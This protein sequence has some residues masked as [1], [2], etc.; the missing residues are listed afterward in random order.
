MFKQTTDHQI[1]QQQIGY[2]FSN[3]NLIRQAFVRK[4]FSSEHGGEDNEVLEF[5]GDKVLDFVVVKYLAEKYGNDL[6]AHDEIPLSF[7][8]SEDFL[9]YQCDYS[10]GELTKIKQ[11]LVERKTLAKRIDELGLAQFLIMGEG[12]KKRRVENE[13]SVKED[14]FEAIIG[15]VALDCNWNLNILQ[16]VVLLMLC[17]E[18]FL[19]DDEETDYVGLIYEWDEKKNGVIPQFWYTSNSVSG[20]QTTQ[21]ANPGFLDFKNNAE[22]RYFCKVQLLS[23]LSPF[24]GCGSSKHD[25]RKDACKKAYEYLE[26]NDML[27]DIHDEIANPCWEDSISQLETLSRRGYFEIPKYIYKESH[28]KN[29]NPIWHVECHIEDYDDFFWAEGSSKKNAKKDAAYSMLCFV[30]DLEE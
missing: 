12:D 16:E 30:L 13:D 26:E 11:R 19:N 7:R 4:S 28:D 2:T 5:I 25:A 14:L 27:Y 1:V 23:D 10:E 29:G 15:A 6:H 3:P 22:I 18:M 8:I 24:E 21:P 9:E 17:P 20:W